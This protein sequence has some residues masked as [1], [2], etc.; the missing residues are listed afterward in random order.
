ML[1]SLRLSLRPLLNS[2]M[3]PL[4][5]EWYK[6]HQDLVEILNL[7]KM[8]STA[9]R[10]TYTADDGFRVLDKLALTMRRI[11]RLARWNPQRLNSTYARRLVTRNGLG[12]QLEESVSAR[13]PRERIAARDERLPPDDLAQ[14]GRRFPQ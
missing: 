5:S 6:L 7:V 1:E 4:L 12:H 11:E 14:T 3:D 8:Q 9:P 10:G 13:H 2:K